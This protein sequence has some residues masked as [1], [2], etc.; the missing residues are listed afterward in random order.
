MTSQN[1]NTLNKATLTNIRY[2][3]DTGQLFVKFSSGTA[4]E[5]EDVPER[6]YNDIINKKCCLSEDPTNSSVNFSR[7]M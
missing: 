4:Y 6:I 5:F 3:Q 7:I 2:I 1:V